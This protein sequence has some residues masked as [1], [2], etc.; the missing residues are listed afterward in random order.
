MNIERKMQTPEEAQMSS[1]LTLADVRERVLADP[2][3]SDSKRS[4]VASSLKRF[5]HVLHVPPQTSPAEFQIYRAKIKV[6]IPA[7][8]G[9]STKR[10]QNILADVKFAFD[11]YRIKPK[12]RGQLPPPVMPAWAELRQLV[13]GDYHR[14]NSLSRFMTYCSI[15]GIEPSAVCDQ[16]LEQFQTW[17]ETGT[18]SKDPAKL[19][20]QTIKAWNNCVSNVSGW[21]DTVL[22]LEPARDLYGATWEELPQSLRDDMDRWLHRLQGLDLI[23]EDGP[24]NPVS[25]TTAENYRYTLRQ[26]IGALRRAGDDTSDI[27]TLS[28]LVL[29]ERVVKAFEYLQSRTGKKESSM[30]AHIASRV[31]AIARYHVKLPKDDI[32]KLSRLQHRVS[33]DHVGLTPKNRERLAQFESES[34]QELLLG[35]PLLT[36]EELTDKTKVTHSDAMRA[37][38]ALVVELLLFMPVRRKNLVSLNLNTHVRYQQDGRRTRIFI[39]FSKDEVKNHVDLNFELPE[40]TIELWQ[41]YLEHYRSRLLVGPDAGFLFPGGKAGTHKAPEQLGRNV[42]GFIK[43]ETGLH[44]NLHLFRD[45][46]AFLYLQDNPGDYETVRRTLAHLKMETTTNNYTGLETQAATRHFDEAIIKRRRK[47]LR[48]DEEDAS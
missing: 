36:F 46:A 14:Q 40:E 32:K 44:V 7:Q 17:L 41:T 3:L 18:F 34:N 16:T 13:R 2:E 25:I 42:S 28:D 6:F 35:L 29:P 11:R 10:W 31:L 48:R 30:L 8:Y 24:S 21:P 4:N 5:A 45:I 38:S 12:T 20:R 37:Q 27:R 1:P 33:P 26:L 9:L 47:L 39:Q 15:H 22:H 43:R 23:D 19:A